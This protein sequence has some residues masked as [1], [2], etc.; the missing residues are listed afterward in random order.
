MCKH[1]HVILFLV[2]IVALVGCT[3]T[4][5]TPPPAGATILTVNGAD[6]EKTYTLEQLQ[7]LP[8]THVESDDGSFVGVRLT[9]ILTDASYDPDQITSVRVIAQDGFSSTYDSALFTREDTVLA[10]AREGGNLN[11]DEQPLRMVL[12]GQ[13]GRMQPRQVVSIEVTSG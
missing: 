5:A 6:I 9:D 13:E 1:H 11:D 12:P 4:D 2:L 3:S 7:G 10:Y 8:V